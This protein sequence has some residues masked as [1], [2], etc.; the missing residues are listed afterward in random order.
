V[1]PFCTAEVLDADL[2]H[3]PPYLV[4]E[5]VA[6]PN[7][8]DVVYERGRLAHG[9]LHSAALGIA[10]ALAAIH[11]AGVIHRDLK[12]DNVLFAMGGVKVIDF[13]I[14]RPIEATSHHTRTDQMVGTISYMAPERFDEEPSLRVGPAADIFAWGAVVTFAGTGRTPFVAESMPATAV[15]I[16]TQPPTLT[17][18]PDP[19]RDIVA[20]TLAKD[21]ADRPTARE[22]VDLLLA[23]DQP[24]G[25]PAPAPQPS[26]PIAP[27]LP[28]PVDPGPAAP[29][30]PD[31]PPPGGA[32]DRRVLRRVGVAVVALIALLSAG[33]LS[34]RLR[35]GGGADVL[36]PPAASAPASAEPLADPATPSDPATTPSDRPSTSGRANAVTPSPIASRQPT[37]STEPPSAAVNT[38]GRD[39]ALNG[40]A[41][42]SS[43]EGPQWPASHAV[44]GDEATRWGSGF[45][46]PQWLRVDLGA[47]WQIS[48]IRLDWENAH[49]TAYRV[50]VS[51][52]GTTWKSVYSTSNGVGGKVV[53]K[54]AKVPARYVRMY[55][56]RR[57]TNYGYSLW[58]LDVR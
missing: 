5:Y 32:P 15:R 6:G 57:S 53:V 52:D 20:R 41:I 1:P 33:L 51:T 17:G 4:F 11:G 42:A 16:L 2:D 34:H 30:D 9:Q 27:Q 23:D 13:G 56:T 48:E 37:R 7:L 8:S 39:L 45:S 35:S 49:A 18:L 50:E 26:A 43:E 31:A 21:P 40:T 44:D 54:V 12:P 3:D 29:V 19:L 22:L 10:T 28:K 58:E 36:A 24:A 38:S 46:D 55:G 25:T 14:A 47:R